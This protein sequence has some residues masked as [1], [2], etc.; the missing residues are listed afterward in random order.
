MFSFSENGEPFIG[1]GV[2]GSG[3][4][5]TETRKVS[6]FDAINVEYPAKVLITQG[7]V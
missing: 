2:R 6:G 5:I 1:P 4:V 7:K 3:N